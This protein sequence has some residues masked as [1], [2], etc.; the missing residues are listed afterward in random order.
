MSKLDSLIEA[1]L[2]RE[3]EELLR[4]A[5]AAEEHTFS[6][7]FEAEL[8]ARIHATPKRSSAVVKRIIALVVAAVLLIGSAFAFWDEIIGLIVKVFPQ[9]SELRTIPNVA[10]IEVFYDFPSDWSEVWIPEYIAT[11]YTYLNAT[12]LYTVKQLHFISSTGSELLFEQCTE[13]NIAFSDNEG[14]S[15]PDILISSH[16]TNAFEKQI[17]THMFRSIAWTDGEY[18]FFLSGFTS[19]DELVSMGESISLREIGES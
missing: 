9:Y 5:D 8:D 17:D 13:D 14:T 4:L 6:P 15:V 1:A 12:E 18:Y 11:D 7:A 16:I 10:P 3:D 19:F 2:L